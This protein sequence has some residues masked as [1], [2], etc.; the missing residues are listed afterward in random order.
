VKIVCD[1]LSELVAVPGDP[2]TVAREIALRGFE[3]ASVEHR[4]RPVI[5]FEITA[6]RPDCLSHLGIAREAA[7]IWRL[8]LAA[9]ELAAADASTAPLIPLIDVRI[10]DTALCPRYCAQIFDVNVG[11]SPQWLTDRLE[12]AG[13]HRI[14]NIV[15]VTNYV[16][17]EMGQPMHAFDLARLQGP[18]LVIRRAV[19][20]ERLTTLDGV[21]RTL[22]AE[23][24]VIADAAR[25]VAVAGV[26][27]GHNSEIGPGTTRIALESAWFQPAAVRRTSKRLGLKTEASVRF[28]R[29]ADIDAAPAGIARVAALLERIGAGVRVG[30]LID[31]Y[32]SPRPVLR[33]TLRSSR[34]TRVLGMDIP[35]DDVPRILTPLGF[36]VEATDMER[37]AWT[38]VVPTFRVD[39]TREIDLIEEVGRHYGFDRLP[40]TFPSLT[41]PQAA[42]DARIAHDR[43]VHRILLASG[44]CES[45]T[46]AFIERQAALPFCA[47]GTE[48]AAI[49][50]PLSE[51]FAVLRPS[52]LPGLVDAC[53]HN[54]R[55]ERRDVR[56]FESGSRFTSDGE[57]RAVAFAWCGAGSGV[58]WS[59]QTRA[60]DFFD[61]KGLVEEIAA[62]SG[63]PIEFAPIEA[64]YLAPGRAADVRLTAAGGGGS[65]GTVG[66][67]KSAVAEAR[68]FPAGEEI[69]VG[70][71]DLATLAA[72]SAGDDFRATPLPRFPSI[73]RDI[74]ILV[75][76]ALPAAAVRGTIRSEAPDTLASIAE[77]DRYQGK[78]VPEGRISLSLRLTFRAPD[79]TLTDEEAQAATERI[80][81]ALRKAHSA[82]RR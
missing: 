27:G 1:W 58:H 39:V 69:Y 36:V 71:I 3:V 48:P 20:G 40:A 59:A 50:N 11:P 34:I 41:A 61:A 81:E 60:V 26:M 62:G 49:A 53:A 74:S 31:R 35:M 80:V 78:G 73:V 52:L 66:Q 17:L 44:F 56:V 32:P 57:G 72:A 15:D 51:K 75:D 14:S 29:G 77:F 37:G 19:A 43:A 22:D 21:E 70:E 33:V 82:E 65:L 6:N 45:A 10:D 8:P 47:P 12:A 76:E 30:A 7:T 23:M 13:V 64:G 18:S 25:P 42:P 79:R 24:L 5:D 67:L 28:E 9:P 2:E 16:M 63:V 54:R 4:P 68:G 38:V 46:F 55:R